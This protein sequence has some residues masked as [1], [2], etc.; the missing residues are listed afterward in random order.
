MSARTANL[1]DVGSDK[2]MSIPY[3]E[4]GKHYQALKQFAIKLE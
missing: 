1:K 3:K 4:C 2:S